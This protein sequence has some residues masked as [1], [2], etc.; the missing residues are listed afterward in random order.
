MLCHIPFQFENACIDHTR[1]CAFSFF[2]KEWKTKTKNNCILYTWTHPSL[3]SGLW[4]VNGGHV[5]FCL[6]IRVR[7]RIHI[8]N[9]FV[10]L[11]NLLSTFPVEIYTFAWQKFP[12][13]TD[14]W[15]EKD[16][17]VAFHFDAFRW[18]WPIN[19]KLLSKTLKNEIE[20]RFLW[21]QRN[22]FFTTSKQVLFDIFFL[23]PLCKN[24]IR[25]L[26]GKL[27]GSVKKNLSTILPS[28]CTWNAVFESFIVAPHSS[29]KVPFCHWIMNNY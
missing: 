21:N 29:N 27:N 1:A 25:I 26:N 6:C 5:E 7:S 24:S 10:A 11:N 4:M 14:K 12:V 16:S 23:L 22:S 19:E 9:P 20:K 17:S 28:D 15:K 3:S 18:F 13:R 2:E 8:P